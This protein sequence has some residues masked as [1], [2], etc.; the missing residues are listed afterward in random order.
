MNNGFFPNILKRLKFDWLIRETPYAYRPMADPTFSS[1]INTFLNDLAFPVDGVVVKVGQHVVRI[2]EKNYVLPY[3][4]KISREEEC[5]TL[6]QIIVTVNLSRIPGLEPPPCP[7][8]EES[9]DSD[10]DVF[11]EK[12]DGLLFIMT[13]P[14]SEGL[15][16][17][18]VLHHALDQLN[19]ELPTKLKEQ[20]ETPCELPQTPSSESSDPEGVD[21]T[22]E[23]EAA[24]VVKK[25][26]SD[27]NLPEEL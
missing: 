12:W 2:G 26:D 1:R 22:E 25:Y 4:C 17:E 7:T 23:A 14:L 6:R 27:N 24:G 9:W 19:R 21:M 11:K 20:Q 16:V 8:Q 13:N 5:D 15:S 3:E 18:C 10:D